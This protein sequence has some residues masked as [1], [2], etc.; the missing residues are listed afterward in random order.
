VEL[1]NYDILVA[2]E[3]S[4]TVRDAFIKE[5][6]NAISC[7][8]R[9]PESGGPHVKGDAIETLQ[10]SDWDGLIA[11]PPCTYLCNS[12]VRWLH[13]RDD[14]WQDM[15]DGAVF[16][17]DFLKSEIPHIAVENPIMHK[18]AR[19]IVGE[20]YTQKVQ[21]YE[22]GVPETKATCFWMRGLPKLEPTEKIPKE[23]VND[24]IH[25]MPP[26]EDRSKKRSVFFKGV[27][28]AMAKQW[29]PVMSND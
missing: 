20:N 14:R 16:F 12:G 19:K 8:I 22:F 17:R 3:F 9:E 26:S 5:G 7:D 13:E 21:P 18:Y 2:C 11:H 4:G 29:G 28:E 25:K 6:Y 10:S 27:A 23:E 24:S 15:L 1:N